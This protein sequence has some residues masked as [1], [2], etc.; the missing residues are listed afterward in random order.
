MNNPYE[1]SFDDK[2]LTR[3]ENYFRIFWLWDKI[4]GGRGYK[5]EKIEWE[6][7]K[8]IYVYKRDAYVID[9]IA[10]AFRMADEN[11]FEINENMAGWQ[12]LIDEL[13]ILFSGVM[14]FHE[15]FV[16]VAFPA[17]DMNLIQIYKRESS[18]SKVN[19]F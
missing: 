19:S 18:S 14:P 9:V 12:T 17:F 6:N 5:E 10:M 8:E 11:A 15:W 13:P 1:I 16:E 3:R 4:T 7:V 2:S